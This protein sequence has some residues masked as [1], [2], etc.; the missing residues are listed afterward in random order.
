MKKGKL[1]LAG[2]TAL[3]LLAGCGGDKGGETLF[4]Y[5]NGLIDFGEKFNS[6][7][8][9][10]LNKINQ[11]LAGEITVC[12][13]FE[14]KQEGWKEVAKEY[15]RLH[16]GQI[17]IKINSNY[18][19]DTYADNVQQT[20]SSGNG[21]NPAWNIVQG[22][23]MGT[24]K[25]EDYIS[26]V[27]STDKNVYAGNK[28]WKSFLTTEAFD[29]NNDYIV[30]TENLQTAWFVNKTALNAAKGKGYAHENPE[31][32]EEL[33]ELCEAMQ[34]AGYTYPL[35]LS[36]DES[37]IQASQFSWLLRIYGD[38][39]YR[40]EYHK[41]TEDQNH[42]NIP[43]DM[44]DPNVD[45]NFKT[46][47]SRLFNLILDSDS[48]NYVGATSDKFKEFL[49]QFKALSKYIN[50]FSTGQ[51]FTQVRNAFSTQ[52]SSNTK[53]SPQILLD[54][55]GEG[56]GFTE[57]T[58]ESF[59]I[60]Y[61]DNP[62]MTSEGGFIDA[63]TLL[64]DVGGNGGYLSIATTTNSMKAQISDDFIK[65]FLS[66]Y[67]QSIY[68]K[69]L[70]TM[71]LHPQGITTVKQEYVV[72]PEQWSSFFENNNKVSFSGLCDKNP[73]VSH[74]I[75]YLDTTSEHTNDIVAE[76]WGKLMKNSSYTVNN[77]ATDW[78]AA[79]DADWESYAATKHYNPECIYHPGADEF[80][81]S[82]DD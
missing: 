48:E 52:T 41:V 81:P 28:Q 59:D 13:V 3:T 30:N 32:F 57:R 45:L 40:N 9:P 11:D 63:N 65:F 77:F 19:S 44:T 71:N 75:R 69:K 29:P 23:L 14:G 8:Y 60:D 4:T 53:S 38:F 17:N 39:Y 33:I 58:N 73:F 5:K 79:L 15:M 47:D 42:L 10:V 16:E 6:T 46:K 49:S 12:L 78:A 1:I 36:L 20:L 61:F 37:S 56:L 35:G 66:P 62:Y 51:S 26:T 74:L 64:R 25:K 22:N 34:E 43:Y 31:T 24:L 76:N 80:A 50:P 7:Y 27:S 21:T 72:I 68:Y 82:Y 55:L 70:A 54:Y 2:L 18:D 67:G